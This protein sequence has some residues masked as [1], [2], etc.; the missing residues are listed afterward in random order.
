MSVWAAR[1]ERGLAAKLGGLRRAPG[2]EVLETG[3]AIWLRGGTPDESLEKAVRSLPGARRFAVLPDRQL[4][5]AG[6]TVPRGRLPEGEWLKL[7]EWMTVALE[8]AAL[9]GRVEGRVALAVVR[10]TDERPSNVLWTTMRAWG[11]WVDR[12]AQV[13]LDRLAFA[14]AGSDVVIRGSPLPPVPG[15]RFV[16]T[17]GVAVEAGWTWSPRLDAG[18]VRQALGLSPGDLAVLHGNGTWDHIEADGFVRA[19]RSSVRAS[20]GGDRDA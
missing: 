17:D 14:M 3:D 7:S 13:R 2:V 10:S 19:T 5:A 11:D 1:L 20:A 18:V 15:R 8:P 6:S 9:A 4:V 12:A 16:E